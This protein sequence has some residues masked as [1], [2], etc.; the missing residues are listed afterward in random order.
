MPIARGSEKERAS[1]RARGGEGDRE[2]G[3]K[4]EGE[5]HTLSFWEREKT[6]TKRVTSVIV[7]YMHKATVMVS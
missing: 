7:R 4:R 5:R 6:G 2:R 1:E 3:K